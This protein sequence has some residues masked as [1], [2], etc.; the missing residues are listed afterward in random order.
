MSIKSS[1]VL[2]PRTALSA[3]NIAERNFKKENAAH[4]S[5]TQFVWDPKSLAKVE[6]LHAI[7][8]AALKNLQDAR[9]AAGFVYDYAQ[10][11]WVA[12]TAIS[13]ATSQQGQ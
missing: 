1:T 8:R 2:A 10:R 11:R 7:E 3:Y 6:A 12:P 9:D 5:R 4:N 13:K